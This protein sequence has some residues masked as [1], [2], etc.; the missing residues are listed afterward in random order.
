MA[1]VGKISEAADFFSDRAAGKKK[2]RGLSKAI[3][4]FFACTGISIQNSVPL[5]G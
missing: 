1:L 3:A 5:P 4:Y 2:R